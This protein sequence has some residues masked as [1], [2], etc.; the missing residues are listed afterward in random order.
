MRFQKIYGTGDYIK[1]LKQGYTCALIV[2]HIPE[3]RQRKWQ[4]SKVP[5]RLGKWRQKVLKVAA[6]TNNLAGA[7]AR[8]N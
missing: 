3:A 4:T 8:V 6:Q 7:R 5:G 2:A 1:N